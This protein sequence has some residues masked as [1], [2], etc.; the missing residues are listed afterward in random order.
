MRRILSTGVCLVL[1]VTAAMGQ[2]ELKKKAVSEPG[3]PQVTVRMVTSGP[4]NHFFGYYG[5]S[6]WNKSQTRMLCLESEF[7]DRLPREG[8][9]AGV[10]VLDV[11]TGRIEVVS[12]TRSWNM[13]Q[14]AMLLWNPKN[15]DTEFFY[16]DIV[17]GVLC[18]VLYN[19]KTGEKKL[20][21]PLSG[22]ARTG[23][24]LPSVSY[25]RVSRMRAVVS[26]GGVKD[27]NPTVKHPDNDGVYLVDINTGERKLLVSYKRAA[28]SIAPKFP[29]IRDRDMWIEHVQLS[30]DGKRL[31]FMPRT[32]GEIG[33]SKDLQ[34]AMYTINIDGT[35][36]REVSPYDGLAGHYDWRNNDELV[37]TTNPPALGIPGG[38][39]HVL[40]KDDG[41]QNF[42]LISKLP[43]GGGSHCCFDNSGRWMVTN[44]KNRSAESFVDEVWL[45]DA[46]KDKTYLLVGMD[47]QQ[48]R[49]MD[50]DTR[51]DIHPRWSPDNT[52]ICVDA[53]D[54]ETKTRQMFVIELKF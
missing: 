23:D 22:T 27:P 14:G 28:D 40:V 34:T 8:E 51:C 7:N 53:I 25:G 30:P 31:M 49:F 18:S 38:K 36:M 4:K 44:N 6:P 2:K 43:F 35:D 13:Q 5:I 50:G 41:K 54:P 3:G 33:G 45:W 19:L 46:E 32:Y 17:D 12:D 20:Y 15:P 42:R 29:V 26:Y 1:A 48:S 21:P 24:Y 39:L 16:N 10:C 37:V 52:M 9:A 47:M 11:A